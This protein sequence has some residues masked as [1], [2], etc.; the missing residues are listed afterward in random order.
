MKR[1][2]P[3]KLFCIHISVPVLYYTL[4][5]SGTSFIPLQHKLYCP[6]PYVLAYSYIDL[7]HTVC[8]VQNLLLLQRAILIIHQMATAP[9]SPFLAAGSSA[10]VSTV[11]TH[12][13]DDPE[14]FSYLGTWTCFRPLE[15]WS[16]QF[17]L[18]SPW[19]AARGT[20]PDFAAQYAL[21]SLQQ[22]YS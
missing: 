5:V 10:A 12:R 1:N 22:A 8:V 21:L 2:P 13:P 4:F 3:C 9:L 16:A 17:P 18:L 11:L 15:P 14:K 6:V 19:G 7:K 20:H